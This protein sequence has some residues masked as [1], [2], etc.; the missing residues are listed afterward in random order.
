[1]GSDRFRSSSA[2]DQIGRDPANR[3]GKRGDIDR[4]S[5]WCGPEMK[6]LRIGFGS[7]KARRADFESARLHHRSLALFEPARLDLALAALFIP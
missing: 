4:R 2:I 5:E 1:V 7:E 3:R 6:S